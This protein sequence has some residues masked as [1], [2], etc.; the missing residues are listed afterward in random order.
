MAADR[1]VARGVSDLVV[2]E[3]RLRRTLAQC[4]RGNL[5]MALM[6]VGLDGYDALIDRHGHDGADSVRS[7]AGVRLHATFRESDT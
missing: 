4:R 1:Q 3:D 2:L 5:K 7:G 6:V